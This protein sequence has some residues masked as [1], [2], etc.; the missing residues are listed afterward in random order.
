MELIDEERAA[1]ACNGE[2]PYKLIGCWAGFLMVEDEAP[3][4][5]TS[6]RTASEAKAIRGS[7][8]SIQVLRGRV[9]T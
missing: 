1:E 3:F 9:R 4:G 8:K 5:G 6:K 7:G 2:C